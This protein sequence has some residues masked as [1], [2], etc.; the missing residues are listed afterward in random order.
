M[1]HIWVAAQSTLWVITNETDR[2]EEHAVSDAGLDVLRPGVTRV[3]SEQTPA[4]SLT[5]ICV[6]PAELRFRRPAVI[7][8]A[9]TCQNPTTKSVNHVF[10]RVHAHLRERE[11]DRRFAQIP[12]RCWTVHHKP[13]QGRLLVVW[14]HIHIKCVPGG[15]TR[16]WV[17]H[18]RTCLHLGESTCW[19]QCHS[20]RSHSSVT[21]CSWQKSPDN[22]PVCRFASAE[23]R[24]TFCDTTEH[25]DLSEI[26]IITPFIVFA[27]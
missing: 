5:V 18:Q 1:Q 4:A 14:G 15:R 2:V 6:K 11:K 22:G 3:F 23:S 13:V 17:L 27:S 24:C 16:V 8:T 12:E 21:C 9:I 7:H 19:R 20:N 10:L 26:H 25:W